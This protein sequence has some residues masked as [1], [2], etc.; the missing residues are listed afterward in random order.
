MRA[1]EQE[2]RSYRG[3]RSVR[4]EEGVLEPIELERIGA[5]EVERHRSGQELCFAGYRSGGATG[6][7]ESWSG[8]TGAELQGFS[9]QKRSGAE[10]VERAGADRS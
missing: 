1:S 7:R 10:E 6:I 8:E 4:A 5:E 2:R 3:Y 9:E